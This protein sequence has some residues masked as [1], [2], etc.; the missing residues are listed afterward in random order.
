MTGGALLHAARVCTVT[1]E[2][3]TSERPP[4]GA[5]MS[6]HVPFF[7]CIPRKSDKLRQPLKCTWSVITPRAK[8]GRFIILLKCK[9]IP[10]CV[11]LPPAAPS[12]ESSGGA[13]GEPSG[14][15]SSRPPSVGGGV[16]WLN[17]EPLLNRRRHNLRSQSIFYQVCYFLCSSLTDGVLLGAARVFIATTKCTSIERRSNGGGVSVFLVHHYEI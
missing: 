12:A 15:A 10:N 13:S 3:N 14:V 8:L 17:H 2:Q 9:V 16:S 5:D 7:W 1:V 4:N 11:I 6:R